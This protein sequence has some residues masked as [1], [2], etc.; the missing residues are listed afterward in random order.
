MKIELIF[1]NLFF[2]G[3]NSKFKKVLNQAG[4]HKVSMFKNSKI[5][6]QNFMVLSI[7]CNN[8]LYN[9]FTFNIVSFR[10]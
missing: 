3:G 5:N 6:S 8:K 7:H 1:Q 2:F 4:L 10:Y 9:C